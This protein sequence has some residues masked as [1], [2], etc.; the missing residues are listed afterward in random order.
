MGKHS[1][2]S[3]KREYEFERSQRVFAKMKGYPYWPARIE[4]LPH[5]IESNSKSSQQNNKYQ[6]M[7]YGTYQT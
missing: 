3:S 7:F 2:S 5:E 6:V 1:S 4:L